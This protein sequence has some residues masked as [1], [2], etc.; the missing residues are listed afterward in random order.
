MYGNLD[1]SKKRL[2]CTLMAEE[3]A[4]TARAAESAE[5]G[6]PY[7]PV[8]LFGCDLTLQHFLQQVPVTLKDLAYTKFEPIRYDG[9][10]PGYVMDQPQD[11]TSTER[12]QDSQLCF[13]TAS[14]TV[15]SPALTYEQYAHDP[16]SPRI[17]PHEL[18]S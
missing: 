7:D 15:S 4:P 9:L 8:A 3:L 12:S 5:A 18:M 1:I 10:P 16:V 11:A 17:L 6:Q 13:C 2:Y 14:I